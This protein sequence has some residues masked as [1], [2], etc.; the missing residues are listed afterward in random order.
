[1]SDQNVEYNDEHGKTGEEGHWHESGAAHQQ[2]TSGPPAMSV[3][4]SAAPQD[5]SLPVIAAPSTHQHDNYHDHDHPNPDVHGHLHQAQADHND[6]GGQHDH[7]E[8]EGHNHDRGKFGWLKE[9]LPF[10]HGHSHDAADSLDD[11]LAGSAEGIRAVKV[12]LLGLGVTSLLQLVVVLFSGSVALLADTIHNFADASTAIPLWLAFS[13]SRK[14]PTRRYTYGYGRAED[15]AGVFVVLMIIS[16]TIVAA[17]VSVERLINPRPITGLEWVAAASLVGFIGNEVVARY[18]IRAGERIGSAALVADGYHAR[19]DGF[20]SLAVLFGTAGVWLGFP[21]ADPLIGLGI[22]VAILFVL[23]D[24]SLQIWQ[25][26]MDGVDPK[27]MTGVENAARQAE[28]V[29]D[30]SSVK[31]RW[32]GHS[33]HVEAEITADKDM[34]LSEAH[35]VAEDVRHAILHKVPKVAGVTVHV[36]PSQAD[37]FDPH[38]RLDHHTSQEK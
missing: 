9:L 4:K 5:I 31:A 17:W 35:R 6:H 10:G 12:S 22:T 37:G 34:S 33:I 27:I 24:A 1:M 16:S 29:Q 38:A 36:D 18:R 21:L 20:T 19:T 15:L 14:P 11:A 25:R 7:G 32:I 30:V 13:L 2:D 8:H 26:L 28:G 23:K 3:R